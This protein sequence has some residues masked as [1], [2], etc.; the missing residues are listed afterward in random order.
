MRPAVSCTP[1][2]TSSREQTGDIID[3]IN[4][5]RNDSVVVKY[6]INNIMSTSLTGKQ[7]DGH[8]LE[9]SA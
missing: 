8:V 1:Y 5:E 3:N 9:F 2:A 6:V 4:V 7:E